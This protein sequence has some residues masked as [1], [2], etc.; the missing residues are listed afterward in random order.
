MVTKDRPTLAARAI[1]C[2]ADQR[3]PAR[4][5]VIVSQGTADYR[6]RLAGLARAHGVT[7]VRI[8]D[9]A[10]D[11]PLGALRNLSLDAATGEL[12]CVW[13][14]DDCCHPDRLRTQVAELVGSRSHT[15]FLSDHLQL[16]EEDRS[17]Y[18]I[19]W[20]L[21]TPKARYPLLP[22][23][24]LMT[25]DRRFRYPESGRYAHLGEDWALLTDLHNQVQVSYVRG[26]GHLYLYNYHGHNTFSA[27]HHGKLRSR[28]RPGAAIA[29]REAE[30]RAV[31]AYYAVPN[32][33]R[34]H[35]SDGPV[36]SI[37]G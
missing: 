22:S 31:M 26:K 3:Y 10:P 28:S 17:L 8:V 15:S 21:G 2:F 24:M 25:H 20:D 12:V 5:L 35:G 30:I 7:E 27:T 1:R 36:F 37:D 11:L 16:F 19:D 13:D 32:P 34:V 23:T 6:R 9:A 33:V 14:D 4:E 29:E 18:W